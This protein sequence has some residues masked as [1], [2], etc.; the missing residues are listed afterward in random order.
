M[1]GIH[2][3]NSDTFKATTPSNREITLTRSSTRRGSS[4]SRR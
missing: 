4:C 3:A 2:T 1:P